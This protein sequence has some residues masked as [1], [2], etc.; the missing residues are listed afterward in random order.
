MNALEMEHADKM[1]YARTHMAHIS[2]EPSS[3]VPRDSKLISQ[4]YN[5]K[6]MSSCCNAP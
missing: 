3:P 2:A 1:R 6:V 4:D 5:V